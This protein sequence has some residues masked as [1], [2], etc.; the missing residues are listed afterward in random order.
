MPSVASEAPTDWQTNADACV[1]G[2]PAHAPQLDVLV[3]TTVLRDFKIQLTTDAAAP[4][5]HRPAHR[6]AAMPLSVE[7][8]QAIRRT[9]TN[10]CLFA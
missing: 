7:T 4:N 6:S 5:A 10:Y 2:D 1:A 3:L 8:D 9:I